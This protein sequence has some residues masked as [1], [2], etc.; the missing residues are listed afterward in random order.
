VH[1]I[2]CPASRSYALVP[3]EIKQKSTVHVGEKSVSGNQVLAVD[4]ENS[5]TKISGN[6]SRSS[7]MGWN[8]WGSELGPKV[9]RLCTRS[10][11]SKKYQ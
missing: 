11:Q 2:E 9:H 6:L 1:R 5:A 3:V 8:L 4:F 10:I 7:S